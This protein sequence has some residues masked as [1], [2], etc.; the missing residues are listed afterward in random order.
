MGE[1]RSWRALTSGGDNLER[2]GD[3]GHQ[4]DAGGRSL[5][6]QAFRPIGLLNPFGQPARLAPVHKRRV[7]ADWTV[8]LSVWEARRTRWPRVS[9]TSFRFVEERPG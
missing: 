3:R 4:V 1:L 8:W 6:M 2:P 5:P 7:G 9:T